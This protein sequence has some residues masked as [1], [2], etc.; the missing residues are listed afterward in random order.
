[1]LHA[2]IRLPKSKMLTPKS[3]TAEDRYVIDPEECVKL[4]D[5]NTIGI[6]AIIGTTYTGEYEDVKAINDLLVKG[7]VDCPI[8]V[9]VYIFPLNT[10]LIVL[11]IH[12]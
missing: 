2:Y 12:S 1:M 10:H 7:N 5:E 8:H 6:C 11:L 3:S 9:D 4:V